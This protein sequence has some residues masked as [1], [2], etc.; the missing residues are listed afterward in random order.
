MSAAGYGWPPLLIAPLARKYIGERSRWFLPRQEREGRITAVGRSGR[1][2][3]YRRED[4]DALLVADSGTQTKPVT[5][6]RSPM[7]RASAP[8]SNALDR[9]AAIRK[10]AT[11]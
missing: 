8:T 1:Y 2:R 5:T 6:V 10:G 4:L 9:L 7:R 3:V 11:R